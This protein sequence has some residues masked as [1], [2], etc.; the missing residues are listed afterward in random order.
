MKCLFFWGIKLGLKCVTMI[1]LKAFDWRLQWLHNAWPGHVVSHQ[2]V[3][4]ISEDTMAQDIL[5]ILQVR[6]AMFYSFLLFNIRPI[7]YFVFDMIML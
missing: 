7:I 5:W 1:L 4:Y 6:L 2:A 3:H